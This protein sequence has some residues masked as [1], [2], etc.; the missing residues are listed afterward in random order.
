[1]AEV[2]DVIKYSYNSL[3]E[4]HKKYLLT[5]SVFENS[6]FE[7]DEVAF[8]T[9]LSVKDAILSLLF[10]K[11]KNL[12]E[13]EQPVLE[14]GGTC[15][16]YCLHPLV[17]TF[18][19]RLEKP[20]NIKQLYL[21]L[22]LKKIGNV[23][24]THNER[25]VEAFSVFKDRTA[26]IKTLFLYLQQDPRAFSIMRSSYLYKLSVFFGS[27][28]SRERLLE[29]LAKEHES[30]GLKPSALYWTVVT[31]TSCIDDNRFDKAEQHL[32]K[33][34]EEIEAIDTSDHYL[35]YV[36][37]EYFLTQGRI[38]NNKD[39]YTEAEEVLFKAQGCFQHSEGSESRFPE[40]ARTYN[41]LGNICFKM[42]NYGQSLI[43]HQKASDLMQTHLVDLNNQE[44]SVYVFN[45]GTVKVQQA[46][47]ERD[48]NRE[49]ANKLYRGALNDFNT[50]M[51]I[52]VRL[53]LQRIPSYPV[54]L[55]Q[56]LDLS[57][58][59]S[60]SLSIFAESVKIQLAI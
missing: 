55:L 22:M 29:G 15:F 30:K 7:T 11:Y 2:I 6:V 8:M 60:L 10:L 41:A 50:S 34:R 43:Y 59:L 48:S 21:E 53:N 26:S 35:L 23:E 57:L 45:L 31:A 24:N 40:V 9:Q 32:E 38:Y 28:A 16:M 47:N 19:N 42:K 25:F 14:K 5:L 44:L 46:E 20:L 54:K 3:D 52:D 18:L 56:R 13:I 1:M 4:R 49:L 58:S 17:L 33:I 39:K 37:G 51:E 27:P 36:Q 12:V